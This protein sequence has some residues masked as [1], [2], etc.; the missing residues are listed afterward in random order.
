MFNK[1]Q[2]P[3]VTSPTYDSNVD[4]TLEEYVYNAVGKENDFRRLCTLDLVIP[5]KVEE[6]ISNLPNPGVVFSPTKFMTADDSH[7]QEDAYL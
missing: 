7:D 4:N 6:E 1:Y 3:I 2:V 5:I